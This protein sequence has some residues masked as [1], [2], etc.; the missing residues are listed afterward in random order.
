MNDSFHKKE[1]IRRYRDNKATEAELEVFFYLLKQG[2]INNE[3]QE[4]MHEDTGNTDVKPLPNY[5]RRF[6]IISAAAILVITLFGSLF[7]IVSE[8]INHQGKSVQQD[9]TKREIKPG[10]DKAILYLSDGSSIVLDNAANG[11]LTKQGDATIFKNNGAVSYK[12]GTIST[13][14]VSYNTLST[15]KGG[16]FQMLLADGSRVW[17]NA[18]SSIRFPTSFNGKERRV[19]LKGEAYFEVAK[20]SNQPFIVVSDKAEIQ[21]LGTH[22]NVNAYEDEETLNTTLLEGSVNV[23]TRNNNT[24][25][26]PGQQA[27]LGTDGIPR[28]H[29]VDGEHVTA[30]KNGMFSFKGASIEEIMRQLTRWYD[31]TVKYERKVTERFYVN[32]SRNSSITDILQILETTEGVH[33][34]IEGKL[35]TVLP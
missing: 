17:L 15:P 5:R 21:V 16:Q 35:V 24:I 26:R 2:E 12:Q 28:V 30:W 4:V 29:T 7:Y 19:E 10:S 33:F 34:K 8:K 23:K 6:S 18:A 31:F 13:Q 22:F 14:E 25:I 11:T 3:L 32:V 20:K 9:N 27:S 1:L